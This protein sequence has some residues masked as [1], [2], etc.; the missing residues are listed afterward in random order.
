MANNGGGP[1]AQKLILDERPRTN[2][3]IGLDYPMPIDSEQAQ[4][5][6]VHFFLRKARKHRFEFSWN[7]DNNGL[8]KLLRSIEIRGIPEEVIPSLRTA[9]EVAQ[10]AWLKYGHRYDPNK[11]VVLPSQFGGWRAEASMCSNCDKY[12]NAG[13]WPAGC[14]PVSYLWTGPGELNNKFRYL[15]RYLFKKKTEETPI[16]EKGTDMHEL[17]VLMRNPVT[18]IP[19]FIEKLAEGKTV[20]WMIPVCSPL[21]GFRAR[22]PDAII[23]R[24]EPNKNGE[25]YHLTHWVIEDKTHAGGSYF[26]QVWAE[27]IIMST[28]GTLLRWNADELKNEDDEVEEDKSKDDKFKH[29]PGAPLMEALRRRLGVDENVDITVDVYV[30]INAYADDTNPNMPLDNYAYL[31]DGTPKPEKV[32]EPMYWS[33]NFRV[34]DEYRELSDGVKMTRS[35]LIEAYKLGYVPETAEQRKYHQT[36][37]KR[38]TKHTPVGYIDRL[39]DG[40]VVLRVKAPDEKTK[41]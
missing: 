4:R 11:P 32:K 26:K 40:G 39:I 5:L 21:H 15:R 19:E 25:G 24:L 33:R 6:I 20:V 8:P 18:S 7:E 30:A 34:R 23:S 1:P 22:P 12:L 29:T 3:T 35:E 9:A 14:V 10:R 17:L 27:G 28:E 38:H 31:R 41:G 36:T 16:M 37:F 2:A 13:G